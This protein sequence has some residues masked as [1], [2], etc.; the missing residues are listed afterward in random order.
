MQIAATLLA[1]G[2]R[3]V[4]FRAEQRDRRRGALGRML[5][6][7]QQGFFALS[8]LQLA[9]LPGL[10]LLYGL[11]GIAWRWRYEPERVSLLL[12]L[13]FP[14]RVAAVTAAAWAIL[15]TAG[16]TQSFIYFAF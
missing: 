11:N 6:P 8:G 12:A 16:D 3:W 7:W 15:L 5:A 9:L 2:A 10:A 13:P 4:L 14:V 1:G